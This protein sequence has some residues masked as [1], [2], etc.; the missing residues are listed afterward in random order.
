M[1]GR[2]RLFAVGVQLFPQFLARFEI[3]DALGVDLDGGA[4]A[5]VAP[6]TG[7][8]IS[9]GKRAETSKLDPAAGSKGIGDLVENSR[10]DRFHITH[11]EMWVIFSDFCY[12]L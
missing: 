9:G 7:I 8:T 10:N 1:R 4:G 2:G 12:Q 11:G 3:W 5:R 6:G